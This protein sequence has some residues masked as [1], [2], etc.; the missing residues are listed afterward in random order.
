MA[1]SGTGAGQRYLQAA[2]KFKFLFDEAVVAVA[3]LGCWSGFPIGVGDDSGSLTGENFVDDAVRD[4]FNVITAGVG[5]WFV[6]AL[7]FVLPVPA[8]FFGLGLGERE[9]FLG[10]GFVVTERGNGGRKEDSPFVG[11]LQVFDDFGNE[12]FVFL[13]GVLFVE[14]AIFFAV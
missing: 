2:V 12:F 5:L 13:L 7:I 1:T 9:I 4:F 14:D 10:D 3:G 8:G 11:F 6:F